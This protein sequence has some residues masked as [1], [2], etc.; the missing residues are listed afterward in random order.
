MIQYQ[1]QL[2]LGE[3]QSIIGAIYISK[4]FKQYRAVQA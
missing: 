4:A 2:P 1:L 3:I